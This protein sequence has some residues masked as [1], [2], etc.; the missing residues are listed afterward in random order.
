ML[1]AHDHV[2]T[3]HP[4]E[5]EP[6]IATAFGE[7][8]QSVARELEEMGC[9]LRFPGGTTLYSE[10]EPVRGIFVVHSGRVK[11]F[12]CSGEGKTLIMRLSK[13]GDVLGLPGTLS[14]QQY[15]VTAETIGPCQ[16][17]FIK[18][19]HFLRFMHAHKEIC[20]AVADQLA[21]IYASICDEMRCLGLSHSASGKLAKLLSEWPQSNGDTPA[22]IK[23][24]F[25][26]EEV[27]QM[28]GTS[29]ETVSRLFVEFKKR[30]LVELNGST[31]HVHD[32]AALQEIAAGRDPAGRRGG[33]NPHSSPEQH[34]NGRGA[35][36][37][38]HPDGV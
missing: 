14:G 8:P 19:E 5:P 24:A 28:I 15:E 1:S 36:G 9:E 7:L 13:P 21:R 3:L 31:L 10:G 37:R 33:K 32:R 18:R 6:R 29:R 34:A 22:R 38:F 16:L 12:I 23:F 17:T 20:L 27:A 25:R 26:H 2:V 30:N 35:D 4:R 11:I